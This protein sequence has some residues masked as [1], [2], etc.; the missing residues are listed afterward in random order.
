MT[1]TCWQPTFQFVFGFQHSHSKDVNKHYFACRHVLPLQDDHIR[2]CPSLFDNPAALHL[3]ER[4]T[5]TENLYLI[6]VIN[7]RVSVK[8]TVRSVLF[9]F[10][11][12]L[13]FRSVTVW[14]PLLRRDLGDCPSGRQCD[15]VKYTGEIYHGETPQKS[16]TGPLPAVGQAALCPRPCSPLV[17]SPPPALAFLTKQLC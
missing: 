8:T 15:R 17:F 16:G 5:A 6:S 14:S 7:K 3:Y 10:S 11:P 2:L 13:L 9:T 4:P 1:N 12:A